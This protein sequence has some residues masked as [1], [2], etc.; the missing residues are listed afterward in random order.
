MESA[1]QSNHASSDQAKISG[2]AARAPQEMVHACAMDYG[3]LR[4][5]SSP[6]R[7][8]PHGV[9][10]SPEGQEFPN[11][12][13]Y[14]EIVTTE[15]L[16]WTNVLA[17]GYRPSKPPAAMPCDTFAFTAVISHEPHGNRTLVIH[18]DEEARKKHED[19]G[20]HDGWGKALDQLVAVVKKM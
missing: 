13:C 1:A 11:V 5:R 17:P 6:R 20:F 19:M 7:Y 9:I 12:G 14:L 3:R 16:V 10:R 2:L 8:L 18:G 15:K 4:N